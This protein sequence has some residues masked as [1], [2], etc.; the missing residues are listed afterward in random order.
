MLGGWGNIYMMGLKYDISE[1]KPNAT[2]AL[3]H[4]YR[5][6]LGSGESA[7]SSIT[8][9]T[10]NADW[11]ETTLSYNNRPSSMNNK[12]GTK[13]SVSTNVG[14]QTLDITSIYNSWKS[15]NIENYGIYITGG[16]DYYSNQR[17]YVYSK[18]SEYPSYIEIK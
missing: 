6:P 3:L 15:G 12:G 16:Q 14:W 4:F 5:Y 17:F 18:E 10:M 11:S 9:G 7:L 1:A 8:I 2:T 13:Y